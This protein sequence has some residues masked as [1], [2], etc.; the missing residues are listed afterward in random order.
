MNFDLASLQNIGA[1]RQIALLFIILFGL[2]TVASIIVGLRSITRDDEELF[3]REKQLPARLSPMK[4]PAELNS[5]TTVSGAVELGRMNTTVAS[6]SLGESTRGAS[7]SRMASMAAELLT[8]DSRQPT[9]TSKRHPSC[10]S[11]WL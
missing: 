11:A 9:L 2:L 5:V 3:V 10:C 7:S 4:A 8:P 6:P 1:D